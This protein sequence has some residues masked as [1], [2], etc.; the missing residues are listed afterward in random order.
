M[1]KTR[2]RRNL[3]RGQ[4]R[5][6]RTASYIGWAYRPKRKRGPRPP[7]AYLRAAGLGPRQL[8]KYRKSHKMTPALRKKRKYRPR[9]IG[10][11]MV[12]SRTWYSRYVKQFAR[13]HPRLRGPALMRAAARS[14][15]RGGRAAANQVETGQVYFNAGRRRR[16]TRRNPVLPY[17]AFENRGRKRRKRGRSR[18]NAWYGQKRRHSAAARKGWRRRKRARRNPILPYA[19]FNPR[20][21]AND[22]LD[23]FTESLE[24]TIS[25]DFWTDTVLPMGAGFIGGQFVGGLIYGLVEKVVGPDVT[26]TGIVPS[27]ARVGS[28]ALGSAAVAGVSMMVTKDSDIAGRVLAGGLVAVLAGIIQEIF[29]METYSKITGMAD[30]GAMAAD[31]T[32]ELK[33]RIAES[34]RSEVAAAEGGPGTSSFVTTQNLTTAPDLGPGPRV[35]DMGSFVTSQQLQTAPHF[36]MYGGGEAEPPVVADVSAF[37]D[38]FADAALV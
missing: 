19:S 27:L 13:K 6:H 7:A 1:P 36:Q 8:R 26:G 25:V 15:R 22:V 10:G 33:E 17:M 24:Q 31:L 12:N 29:G 18:R 20:A 2:A 5:A 11:V 37:S 16:K 14:Y 3:W 32:D 35:S 4:K 23:V 9:R 38:S 28:R 34:V 21:R 30:L